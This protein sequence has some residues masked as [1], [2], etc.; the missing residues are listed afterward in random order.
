MAICSSCVATIHDGQAKIL[1]EEAAN[2]CKLQL[3]GFVESQKKSIQQKK[4]EIAKIDE[5]C[6]KIQAQVG[7]VKRDVQEF[8]DKIIVAVVAK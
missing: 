7:N 4:N 3:K 8:S 2:E 6:H 1:L 5:N